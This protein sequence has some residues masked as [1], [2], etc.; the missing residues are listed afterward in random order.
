MLD[1]LK[2]AP[3]DQWSLIV[4]L[5]ALIIIAYPWVHDLLSGFIGGLTGD[6]YADRKPGWE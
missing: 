4:P 6:T 1:Y 2:G 3:W 5:A